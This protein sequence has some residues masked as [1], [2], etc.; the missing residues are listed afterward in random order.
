MEDANRTYNDI[1]DQLDRRIIEN[2]GEN[3]ERLP[4]QIE[5][6]ILDDFERNPYAE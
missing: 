3:L 1:L 5:I 4:L 2:N 6:P